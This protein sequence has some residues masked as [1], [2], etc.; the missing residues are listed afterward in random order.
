MKYQVLFSLKDKSKKLKCRLFE[1][2]TLRVNKMYEM[3]LLCKIYPSHDKPICCMLNCTCMHK[4]MNTVYG[5]QCLQI[6]LSLTRSS[7]MQRNFSTA[8]LNLFLSPLEKL[9]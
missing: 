4:F 5:T 7:L 6:F 9:P 2:G 1:F 8:V 3:L